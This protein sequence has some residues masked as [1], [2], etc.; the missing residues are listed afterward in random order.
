MKKYSIIVYEVHLATYE[1]EAE[2]LQEAIA[3]TFNGTAE[4]QGDEYLD[5]LETSG[6]EGI[7]SIRYFENEED[8]EETVISSD[9]LNEMAEKG[10]ISIG[11]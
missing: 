6:W 4:L 9:E 11:I 8:E 3:N 2:S 10:A 1:V 5:S 7:G